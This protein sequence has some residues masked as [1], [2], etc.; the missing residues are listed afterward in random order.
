MRTKLSTK[1]LDAPKVGHMRDSSASIWYVFKE[2]FKLFP[3]SSSP[4]EIS[5]VVFFQWEQCLYW[6]VPKCQQAVQV[7]SS[8]NYQQGTPQT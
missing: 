5:L 1:Y 3:F 8:L 2:N 6:S 4:Q 7:R